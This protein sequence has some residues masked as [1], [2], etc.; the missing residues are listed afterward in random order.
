MELSILDAIEAL[1]EEMYSLEEIR[2]GSANVIED[3]E[4]ERLKEHKARNGRPVLWYTD[5]IH[6]IAVY[7][8]TA[9]LLTDEEIEDQLC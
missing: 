1:Y 2:N 5:G 3:Y 8:D 4:A 9:E 7:V 6:N